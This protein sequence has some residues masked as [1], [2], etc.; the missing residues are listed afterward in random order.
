MKL[1]YLLNLDLCCMICGGLLFLSFIL[2]GERLGSRLKHFQMRIR[3]ICSWH[4]CVNSPT[5]LPSAPEAYRCK[6]SGSLWVH[7]EVY[8]K[9]FHCNVYNNRNHVHSHH[10]YSQLQEGTMMTKENLFMSL[11]GNLQCQFVYTLHGVLAKIIFRP[12][13]T[14][15]GAIS[16]ENGTF[17]YFDGT[18]PITGKA[19]SYC[20]LQRFRVILVSWCCL[21]ASRILVQN[22][23]YTWLNKPSVLLLN[24]TNKQRKI[25]TTLLVQVDL[26]RSQMEAA[27][28]CFR[29]A[30]CKNELAY[31]HDTNNSWD[32]T[33]SSKSFSNLGSI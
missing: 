19:V 33:A 25:L 18:N 28:F 14:R 10:I 31:L 2:T 30:T 22:R 23:I 21:Y 8:Q 11:K 24:T 4:F 9:H 6:I 32:K 5:D 27:Q 20:I 17:E 12:C 7:G 1:G 29:A 16:I 15:D 13:V 26:R 3:Y